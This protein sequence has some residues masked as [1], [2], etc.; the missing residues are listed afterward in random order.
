MRSSPV[1]RRD[2]SESGTKSWSLIEAAGGRKNEYGWWANPVTSN[3]PGWAEANALGEPLVG[4][5]SC[6]AAAPRSG[7]LSVPTQYRARR[8]GIGGVALIVLCDSLLSGASSPT[9]IVSLGV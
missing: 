6:P 3:R 2:R 7:W 9:R 5:P 4:Q 1:S 8:K